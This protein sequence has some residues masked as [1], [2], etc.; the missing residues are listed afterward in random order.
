MPRLKTLMQVKLTLAGWIAGV[1][2][3]VCSG[4]GA[5]ALFIA[6]VSPNGVSFFHDNYFVAFAGGKAVAVLFLGASFLFLT[7]AKRTVKRLD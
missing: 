3:L 6:Y 1:A 4:I 5:V 7:L 2:A